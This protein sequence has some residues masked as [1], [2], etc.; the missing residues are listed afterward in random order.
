MGVL[1]RLART[2]RTP[3]AIV[4]GA[5]GLALLLRAPFVGH[6]PF[7]DEAGLLIVAR[8]WHEGGANL[9]GTLFVDRPPLLL[10]FYQLADSLGGI[11]A[12]R[13]M[14]LVAAAVIVATAGWIGNTVA[15]SRG[16][17]WAALAAAALVA[18]PMIGTTGSTA[19]CSVR[20]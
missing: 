2:L 10:L 12:A 14:G 1:R 18:N 11:E 19:S 20:R 3:T 15:G 13:L 5:V 16:T 7:P 17:A 8:N 9:Y 6:L 4:T